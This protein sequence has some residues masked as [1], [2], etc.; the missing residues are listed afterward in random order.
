[1]AITAAQVKELREQ[2]SAPMLDCKKALQEND[3]DLER[4]VAWLREKGLAKV[5]K[6]AGRAAEEGM[7]DSYIHHGNRV[8]VMIEVNCETDFVARS[9]DFTN[10][11]HDLLLH[12]AM[13]DPAYMDEAGVPADVLEQAQAEFAQQAAA[14]G[15][16]AEI[17]EKIVAGRLSKYYQ[18][19]CLLKQPFIKDEDL[20][21]GD[22]LNNT[23]AK[24]GENI[25]VRRF[26]RYEIGN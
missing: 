9:E 23:I 19:V 26:V 3:G 17:A 10:L 8:G 2:T 5:A 14:E 15:K 25:I 13:A 16:P 24:I 21:I 20:T 6:K 7:V 1:M 11:V 18:D 22:L 12:V 4:A